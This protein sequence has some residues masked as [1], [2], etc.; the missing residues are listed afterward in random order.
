M[1]EKVHDIGD[2]LVAGE[3]KAG[4]DK[5][6][7]QEKV[8][9]LENIRAR[10]EVEAKTIVLGYSKECDIAEDKLQESYLDFIK[11]FWY[12][13]VETGAKGVLEEKGLLNYLGSQIADPILYEW[14]FAA[15]RALNKGG[16]AE[17]KP[18]WVKSLNLKPCIFDAY[19]ILE[20]TA[21]ITSEFWENIILETYRGEDQ[22][23]IYLEDNGFVIYRMPRGSKGAYD[24][25]CYAYRLDFRRINHNYPYI[26]EF[27]H[28]KVINEFAG[29]IKSGRCDEY[30][31]ELLIK[32]GK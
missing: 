24:Y 25:E 12:R 30:I 17:Y 1:T 21:G 16:F 26:P 14:P 8:V 5:R 3:R 15:Q 10:L 23:E 19:E 27:I 32:A 20:P 2:F 28:P 6:V 9:A 29:Q 18:K 7:E 11:P 4:K 13:L 31:G 22:A